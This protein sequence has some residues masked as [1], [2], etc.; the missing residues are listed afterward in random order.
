MI[1][2]NLFDAIGIILLAVGFFLAFLPHVAHSLVLGPESGNHLSHVIIG[3][4]LVVIGLVVLIVCNRKMV[5]R[6]NRAQFTKHFKN[7]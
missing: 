1:P 2:E 4:L 7:K 5:E 6:G 3:M